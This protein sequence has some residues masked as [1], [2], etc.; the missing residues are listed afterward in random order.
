MPASGAPRTGFDF[1]LTLRQRRLR[2]L[3]GLVIVMIVGMVG[4]GTRHPFFR[5]AGS[6]GVR[7]LAREAV[8][9]RREGRE[10]APDAERAR[11]AAAVRVAVIGAYWCGC[12]ALSGVLLILAWLDVR[13]IRRKLVE[14]QRVLARS[15]PAQDTAPRPG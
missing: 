3:T 12:F 14:A 2:V 11:R 8:I 9:A 7:A 13:E 6:P 15:D 5:S 4:F 1:R 10:P